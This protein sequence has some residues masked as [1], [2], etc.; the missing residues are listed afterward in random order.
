MS[1]ENL[2]EGVWPVKIGYADS[3]ERI[4]AFHANTWLREELPE[5]VISTSSGPKDY[6]G[7][8]IFLAFQKT[9][10]AKIEMYVARGMFFLVYY[11]PDGK[12]CDCTHREVIIA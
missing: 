3:R 8:R 1:T 5:M 9:S 11:M 6:M 2:P 10:A 4:Q 7:N 12:L